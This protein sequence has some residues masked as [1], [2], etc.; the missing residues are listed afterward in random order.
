MLR[1]KRQ[2]LLLDLFIKFIAQIGDDAQA[3]AT[4]QNWLPVIADSFDQ[5]GYI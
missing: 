3:D 5:E 1:K 2:R 4:H